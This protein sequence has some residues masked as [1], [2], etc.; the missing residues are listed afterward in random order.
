MSPLQFLDDV[1]QVKYDRTGNGR[2]FIGYPDD[3]M[4]CQ[5]CVGVCPAE[6]DTSPSGKAIYLGAEPGYEAVFPW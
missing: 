6:D 4:T 3:C 1:I 2:V 5:L